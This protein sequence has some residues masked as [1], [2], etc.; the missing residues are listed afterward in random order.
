VFTLHARIRKNRAMFGTAK[1]RF[2]VDGIRPH[3]DMPVGQSLPVLEWGINLGASWLASNV[4]RVRAGP[5]EFPGNAA[6]APANGPQE[7]VH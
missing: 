1:V 3:E 4:G 5:P 2:E 7:P 6:R